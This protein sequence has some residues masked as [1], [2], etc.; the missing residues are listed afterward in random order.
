MNLLDWSD[1]LALDGQ[2]LYVWAAYLLAL[3]AI[4]LELALLALRRRN[5][6]R[7]LGLQP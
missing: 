4:T 1:L 7:F 6:R 3:I 2:A 5:I